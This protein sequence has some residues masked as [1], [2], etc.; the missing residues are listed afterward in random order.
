LPLINFNQNKWVFQ[1]MAL[2]TGGLITFCHI[3]RVVWWVELLS[4]NQHRLYSTAC[5]VIQ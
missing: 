1:E 3:N 2:N 4:Q 5:M